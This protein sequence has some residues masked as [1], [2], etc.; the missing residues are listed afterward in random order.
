MLA[1]TIASNLEISS[2]KKKIIRKNQEIMAGSL[3]IMGVL[4]SKK[5]LLVNT[6]VGAKKA[7][8]AARQI[9]KH[10]SPSC[11]LS[12]GAAGAVDPSL[13]TGDIVVVEKTIHKQSLQFFQSDNAL[14]QK[15]FDLISRSGLSVTSGDCLTVNCFIHS[16]KEK[17]KIFIT[18]G[19]RVIDME[20]AAT[21]RVICSSGIPFLNVRVTSDTA[22]ADTVNISSVLKKKRSAGTAGVY[23]HLLKNPSEIL[24]G[25]RL[26]RDMSKAGGI[27]VKVVET[28][29]EGIPF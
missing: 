24:R 21:A 25:V 8:S 26:R 2:L 1:I 9:I 10:F 11:V 29:V 17:K 14:S 28:L 15:F 5:I 3:F 22:R 23:L 7:G 16:E 13:N 20:S 12:V 18:S 27:I 6:G 19:A 4:N